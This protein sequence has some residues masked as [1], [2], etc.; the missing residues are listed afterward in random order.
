VAGTVAPQVA[1]LASAGAAGTGMLALLGSRFGEAGAWGGI[2]LGCAIT[3]TVSRLQGQHWQ[4]RINSLR[5]RTTALLKKPAAEADDDLE[6]LHSDMNELAGVLR[7][8]EEELRS[9]QVLSGL[10]LT[11]MQEGILLLDADLRIKLMNPTLREMLL[12]REDAVG[13]PLIEVVRHAPL[14]ELLRTRDA[15]TSEIELGG[16]K[17]RHLLV[18]TSRLAD[19]GGNLL[20]VFVDVTELRRLESMRRDFVAN[21][22][23]ELR[24]PVTG[25]ISATE[26]LRGALA[27][28]PKAALTFV[29]IIERNAERLRLLIEDI[30]D[31]SRIEAREFRFRAEPIRL[32]AFF[33]H[34]TTLFRE[35][36]EKR[37]IV[38]NVV[39]DSE[40]EL[41]L[42]R[43]ALEQVLSNLI[44]NAVK[45]ANEG[46]T[47]SLRA[48]AGVQGDNQCV[49]LSV[50]DNGPGINAK[51][52]ARLF[53]RFYRVDEGRA[54]K[55]G[56]TGLGLAI[57]K[58]LAEAMN[59][60]LRVESE[61][62]TG[63]RFYAD[64]FT[65]AAASKEPLNRA[66]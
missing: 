20:A 39:C 23:H 2:A 59:G 17:P 54:R 1:L 55:Q 13:R 7:R 32:R 38:L 22:S 4:R 21:V 31:L 12:L 24:T 65:N 48:K 6:A 44:D 29:D 64:W 52:L 58:H 62:G 41:E 50:E 61:V 49:T 5:K 33:E 9:E 60:T 45:Y 16:I 18:R 42:D 63:T 35:R 25:L 53:E 3:L 10:V 14:Q 46:A 15:G 51:H 11:A 8:R 47:V 56:G 34:L 27:K 40:L 37:K 30:L 19:D 57:S 28:D 66:P 36:A 26:T 43:N